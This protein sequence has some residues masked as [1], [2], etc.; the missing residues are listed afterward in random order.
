MPPSVKKQAPEDPRWLS[1]IHQAKGWAGTFLQT[2]GQLTDLGNVLAGDAE[3]NRVAHRR[4]VFQP[5]HPAA[6]G[7]ELFAHGVD[8][9][10][11]DFLALFDAVG[12]H[13]ELGEAGLRQLLVERQ[14]ETR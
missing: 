6:Q 4:A 8:Q 7:G 14:V 3:L 13:H 12:E 1:L 5:R 11:A 10:G 2:A 9:P